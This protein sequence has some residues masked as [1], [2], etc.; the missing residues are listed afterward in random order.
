MCNEHF[1]SRQGPNLPIGNVS[2]YLLL[3]RCQEVQLC[4]LT[5]DTLMPINLRKCPPALPF[6]TPYFRETL[7][8]SFSSGSKPIFATKVSFFSIFRDLQDLHSFAPVETLFFFKLAW[9]FADFFEKST[10]FIK[11]VV[12]RTGFDENSYEFQ[13]FFRMCE[14]FSRWH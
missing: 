5:K 14:E 12:F 7:A 13:W 3:F 8:G 9:N 1:R 10:F 11:F 2:P 6:W 4:Y